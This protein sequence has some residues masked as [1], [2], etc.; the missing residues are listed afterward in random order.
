MELIM[1]QFFPVLV[2]LKVMQDTDVLDL[3][4]EADL[5]VIKYI[6]VAQQY[7]F[8]HPSVSSQIVLDS[9]LM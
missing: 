4:G 7:C 6:A 3:E 8:A 5:N 1:T 9:C 2:H